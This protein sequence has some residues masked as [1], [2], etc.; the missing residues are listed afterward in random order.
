MTAMEQQ[1]FHELLGKMIEEDRWSTQ[2]WDSTPE[3]AK[4]NVLASNPN[5]R[6]DG[7]AMLVKLADK[8]PHS[9]NVCALVAQALAW[10]GQQEEAIAFIEKRFPDVLRSQIEG[11][12]RESDVKL[13]TKK[14]PSCRKEDQ[15]FAYHMLGADLVKKGDL[16]GAE[17]AF[18]YAIDCGGGFIAKTYYHLGL[19]LKDKGDL[20]AA[21]DALRKS[22]ELDSN[23]HFAHYSLG[24]LLYEKGDLQGAEKEQTEAIRLKPEYHKARYFLAFVLEQKGDLTG[25]E[26]AVREAIRLSPIDL[27]YRKLLDRIIRSRNSGLRAEGRKRT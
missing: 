26:H 24:I 7:I 9:K 19:L 21:E 17:V 20:R 23:D 12:Y 13:K 3:L 8:F 5:T 11:V 14:D 15:A 27:S 2:I 25:A 1:Q 6:S 10:D 18:R 22:M 16:Q 4:A